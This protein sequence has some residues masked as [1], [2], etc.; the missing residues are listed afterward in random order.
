MGFWI[1]K[2]KAGDTEERLS[3]IGVLNECWMRATGIGMCFQR[4]P[5]SSNVK[6][7]KARVGLEGLTI[8]TKVVRGHTTYGMST[9]MEVGRQVTIRWAS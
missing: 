2:G 9:K 4:S 3:C 5:L 7:E 1:L 6:R 8:S